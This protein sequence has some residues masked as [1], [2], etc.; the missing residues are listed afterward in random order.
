MCGRLR[1]PLQLSARCL[2]VSLPDIHEKLVYYRVVPPSELRPPTF[3]MLS[4]VFFHHC[5]AFLHFCDPRLAPQS[6]QDNVPQLLRGV[7]QFGIYRRHHKV[8]TTTTGSQGRQQLVRYNSPACPLT[9]GHGTWS[10]LRSENQ[11]ASLLHNELNGKTICRNG[12]SCERAPPPTVN[13]RP[14]ASKYLPAA[15]G[16]N[17]LQPGLPWSGA[18]SS[19]IRRLKGCKTTPEYPTIASLPHGGCVHALVLTCPASRISA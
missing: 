1:C 17:V 5:Q 12:W 4:S 13:R 15:Q 11:Q 16:N 6:V 9:T 19:G 18:A 8:L 2:E 3:G 10:K 7:S 14:K